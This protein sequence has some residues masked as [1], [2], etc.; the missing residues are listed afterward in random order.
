[1]VCYLMKE[2]VCVSKNI[3]QEIVNEAER[4]AEEIRETQAKPKDKFKTTVQ[5]IMDTI[6]DE[7]PDQKTIRVY[8]YAFFW[9]RRRLLPDLAQINKYV[10]TID[11]YSGG[12]QK[13]IDMIKEDL[14]QDP[15][16]SSCLDLMEQI[17][18]YETE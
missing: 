8:V 16:W 2:G 15:N 4:Q 5:Q 1:M 11:A 12:G 3:E 18:L 10:R 13:I 14:W 6:P 17:F 7:N 9:K